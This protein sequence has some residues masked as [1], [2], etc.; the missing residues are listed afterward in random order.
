MLLI[1][2]NNSV[3]NVFLLKKYSSLLY[4]E[5]TNRQFIGE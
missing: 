1:F 2:L 5:K 3:E 4:Q